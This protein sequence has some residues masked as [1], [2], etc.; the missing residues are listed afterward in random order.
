M[1]WP[2]YSIVIVDVYAKTNWVR[3]SLGV[4]IYSVEDSSCMSDIHLDI[5]CW[6]R[7]SVNPVWLLIC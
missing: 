2:G 5:D 4:C 1:A 6:L 3:I 7:V